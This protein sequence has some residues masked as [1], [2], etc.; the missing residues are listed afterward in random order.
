MDIKE[1]EIS[2]PIIINGSI[3]I[4]DNLIDKNILQNFINIFNNKINN[5]IYFEHAQYFDDKGKLVYAKDRDYDGLSLNYAASIDI[6][7][8]EIFKLI[9]NLYLSAIKDY[10]NRFEINENLYFS[11]DFIISKFSKGQ[12][13]ELQ[14]SGYTETGRTVSAILSINDDYEGGEISFV[15]FDF[16]IKPKSG[17]LIIFPSNY[18]YA[19]MENIVTNGTKYNVSTHIS[20]RDIYASL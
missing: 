9:N 19:Y 13:C 3:A 15:N 5:N 12:S 2:I 10:S 18:A 14:F 8:S 20:D 17:T 1:K 16:S 11:D 6:N 7:Y 4:Y